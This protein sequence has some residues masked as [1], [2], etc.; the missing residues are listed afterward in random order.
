MSFFEIL[1]TIIVI[2]TCS[3]GIINRICSCIETCK[4]SEA[5]KEA[6][7][8]NKDDNKEVDD[9]SIDLRCHKFKN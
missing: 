1:L 7:M 9:D 4:F 2:Y 6:L 3:Y 5:Y 8:L